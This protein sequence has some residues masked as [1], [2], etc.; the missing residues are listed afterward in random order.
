MREF[1]LQKVAPVA[2][3]SISSARQSASRPVDERVSTGTDA[4]ATNRSPQESSMVTSPRRAC[5]GMKSR[6]FASK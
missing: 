6:A 4:A 5:S 2:E 1:A 3:S